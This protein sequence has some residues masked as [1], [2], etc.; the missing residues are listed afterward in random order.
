MLIRDVTFHPSRSRSLRSGILAGGSVSEDLVDSVRALCRNHPHAWMVDR[1]LTGVGVKLAVSVTGALHGPEAVGDPM[2]RVP[3]VVPGRARMPA[4]TRRSLSPEAL[5]LTD[6]LGVI[7]ENGYVRI[8]GRRRETIL[9]GGFEIHSC[10]RRDQL[11]AHPA[12][13]DACVIGLPR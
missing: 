5:L 2:A 9:R 1:Q 12:V 4:E 6:D 7:D 3:N 13:D 10:E 11:R 8:V